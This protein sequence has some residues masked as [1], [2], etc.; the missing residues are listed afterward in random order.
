MKNTKIEWAD[1]TFNPWIG[2][3]KVSEGCKNCY[4]EALMNHR[5][6][7][8]KWGKGQPRQLTSQQ[9]WDQVH[10][11]NKTA[12]T[13]GNRPRVFCAS[14]AD[15]LDPE[16]P[17]EWLVDLL[18]LIYKTPNLDWLLLTKRPDLWITRMGEV[19]N[20]LTNKLLDCHC[21]DTKPL[22]WVLSWCANEPPENVW[23]GTSV[24]NQQNASRLWDLARIPAKIR[25]ASCEPLLGL[26]NLTKIEDDFGNTY[27]ALTGHMGIEARGMV[28]AAKLDWVI[29]GGESGKDARPMNPVW[30]QSLQEQCQ[31]SSTAF[32]FK[33]W[34]KWH[35][36]D[37]TGLK[38]KAE[39][40]D[41]PQPGS[42]GIMFAR[43]KD[44]PG[45][46]E[47][48]TR[49]WNELPSPRR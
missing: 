46:R 24:E 41:R 23:V 2:C 35:P 47:L 25:F 9:N 29:V 8:V 7:K 11:W 12:E 15:W 37:L 36:N 21:S 28:N 1:H 42:R 31:S 38:G 18:H 26:V 34:G 3:T 10:L 40:I 27:D 44:T 30:V 5:L 20:H 43:G 13:E 4:A 49:E 22:F 6:K 48:N 45:S 33:Q 39:T 19:K 16:I 14:L 17:V 32:F